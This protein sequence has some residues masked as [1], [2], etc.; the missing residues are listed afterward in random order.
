MADWDSLSEAQRAEANKVVSH[1]NSLS[2]EE[3][4]RVQS[5][6]ETDFEK[7][8]SVTFGGVAALTLVYLGK[9]LRMKL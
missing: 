2:D 1:Y 8:V 5:K 6:T 3:K 7:W 9:R 4:K